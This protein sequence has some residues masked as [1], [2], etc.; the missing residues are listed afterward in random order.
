MEQNNK[1][2]RARSKS[3]GKRT[4]PATGGALA[5]AVITTADTAVIEEDL[6]NEPTRRRI[7]TSGEDWVHFFDRRN[8]FLKQLMS[9]LGNSPTLRRVISDKANMA[10]G[11][12]FIPTEGTSNV[13]LT[14]IRK[15]RKALGFDNRMEELN[16][17]LQSVNLNSESL[18]DVCYKMFFD[19]F[20]FGNTVV[21]FVRNNQGEE[22]P[23]IYMYHKPLYMS[24]VRKADRDLII[25]G[26][27]FLEDW[28]LFYSEREDVQEIPMYPEW[29]DPDEDGNERTCIHVKEYA[30]GF[31]YWGLP[32]WIAAKLWAELEY[33]IPRYN[34]SK[35]VNGYTPSSI[36]QFFGSVTKTEA[37]SI[38][39]DFK[40]S[41]TDTGN[42]SKIFAQVLKDERLKANVQVLEDKNQGNFMDLQKLA[43]QAI[44]TAARWTMSLAGF[45]TAG[46]LGSNQQIRQETEFVHNMA[47][48][49]VQNMILA[50][51]INPF[52]K[53]AGEWTGASWKDVSFTISNN[54]P[55]S[56]FGDINPE[57]NLLANEKRDIMGYDPLDKSGL[58]QLASERK[59]RSSSNTFN[60][61]E[62]GQQTAGEAGQTE[63]YA[64][65]NA[66]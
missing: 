34:I 55:I 63:S 19:H 17:F 57:E 31:F 20:G 41:F 22:G 37:E 64:T 43:S 47:I 23:V 56:F 40:A 21:E 39:K 49:P 28:D 48:K 38:I 65:D 9:L 11:D 2:Q 42:N 30:P 10:V 1:R 6:Y 14:V 66:E 59:N 5:S 12:G 24:A 58:S 18:A 4:E 60:N 50:R 46:K 3:R 15:V 62:N 45:A 52:L 54:I 35:L 13:L 7:E 8:S 26:M 32:D 44:V 29:S 36:V 27:A 61:G 33:R 53:E 16:D 25:Q 51:I